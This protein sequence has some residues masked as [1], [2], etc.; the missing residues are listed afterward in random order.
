MYAGHA[1]YGLR[2]EGPAI[3]DVSP[4]FLLASPETGPRISVR[5]EAT[6]PAYTGAPYVDE[7]GAELDLPEERW[8]QL[9]RSRSEAA[10][11]GS[12][13]TPDQLAHPYVGPLA[14]IFNRWLGREVFHAGAFVADERAW[15]VVGQREAG[16][17]SLL[18][19]IADNGID[20]LAD[21]ISVT[22]GE[23]IF[24]GPRCLDLRQPLPG[25]RMSLSRARDDTRWRL[26]LPH[27]PASC[28][29]GGWLFLRWGD[30]LSL[31]PVPASKLLGRLARHRLRTHL[32]SDP[33][34]LLALANRPAWVVTRPRSWAGVDGTVAAIVSTVAAAHRSTSDVG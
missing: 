6:R 5:Y 27:G 30:E 7:V 20:V 9:D 14:I 19:A 34:I 11:F 12:L 2:L 22:D 15:V 18:A 28:P 10:Y 32:Q 16:K 26:L 23:Q 25:I 3:V 4:F 29:V 17:S 31:T 24:T 8:L 21:D 33:S 13:L 1:V